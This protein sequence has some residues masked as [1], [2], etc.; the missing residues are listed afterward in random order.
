MRPLARA[1]LAAG[2]EGIF[3]EVHPNPAEAL[4]DRETQLPLASLPALLG[5]WARLGSLVRELEAG[6]P[7]MAR[8]DWP[9]LEAEAER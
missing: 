2:A 6:D 3:A 1:A 4:C 9:G 7:P 5:E 8:A